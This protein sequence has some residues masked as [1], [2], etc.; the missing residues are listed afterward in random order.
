MK[1]VSATSEKLL[2]NKFTKYEQVCSK[3]KKFFSED[4]LIYQIG[5]KVD[6][7][8]FAHMDELKAS[9]IEL[10]QTEQLICNLN[11]RVKHLSNLMCTLTKQI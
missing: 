9:K 5:D 7:K 1:E 10:E 11:D 3:F 6:K 8:M 2:D 4:E